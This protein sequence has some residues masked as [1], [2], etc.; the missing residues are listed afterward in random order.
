MIP[1]AAGSFRA[2]IKTCPVLSCSN[3]S[4]A[5]H[6]LTSALPCLNKLHE[7]A[8]VFVGMDACCMAVLRAMTPTL[9]EALYLL[10]A[11]LISTLHAFGPH[12]VWYERPVA[13]QYQLPAPA[14][15]KRR[16]QKWHS[17]LFT[18]MRTYKQTHVYVHARPE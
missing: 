1:C 12:V 13:P 18:H 9:L 11:G 3:P 17:P 6:M 8:T 16:D 7:R 4:R 15:A 5:A 2:R 10:P 14:P